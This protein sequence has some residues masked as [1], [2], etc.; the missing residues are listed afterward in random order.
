MVAPEP[1]LSQLVQTVREYEAQHECAR[2]VDL[3]AIAEFIMDHLGQYTRE[4]LHAA[5]ALLA[6]Y[7][8]GKLAVSD[9]GKYMNLA[10]VMLAEERAKNYEFRCGNCGRIIWSDE[11]KKAGLGSICRRKHATK[12]K[13]MV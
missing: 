2:K 7:Q 1:T 12:R 10:R 6:E 13:E 3:L 8:L 9:R 5:V 11:S 4:E